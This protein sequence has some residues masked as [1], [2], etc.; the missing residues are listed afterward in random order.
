LG[1][2]SQGEIRIGAS[3]QAVLPAWLGVAGESSSCCHEASCSD[4]TSCAKWETIV[5]QPERVPDS[6]LK[7][8]I[9]A[10]RSMAAFRQVGA[11][12][13]LIASQM[14]MES[15]NVLGGMSDKVLIHALEQL[16]VHAYA[17][18][19]SLREIVDTPCAP[20]TLAQWSDEHSR[21][22]AKGLKQCGKN[23]WRIGRELLP[24]RT[25]AEIVEYYYLWK[26]SPLALNQRP[27]AKP[28]RANNQVVH[29][30]LGRE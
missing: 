18:T 8:Y 20:A 19:D 21:K 3:H 11:S 9:T 14:T 12:R 2:G 10:V 23:F 1:D 24:A 7:M 26:K 15:E 16:H 6:E 5:W 25:T 30:P 29:S 28:R 27:R 22:F 17:K 13:G 4:E